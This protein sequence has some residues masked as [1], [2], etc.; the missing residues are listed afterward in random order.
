MEQF[1]ENLEVQEWNW[2]QQTDFSP[3]IKIKKEHKSNSR[4]ISKGKAYN[5]LE[6]NSI[7]IPKNNIS[8]I[9]EGNSL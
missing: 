9:Q 1:L 3:R 5:N 4:S 8:M 6:E 2:H 7:Y